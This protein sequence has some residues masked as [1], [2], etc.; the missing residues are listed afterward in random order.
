LLP[1]LLVPLPPAPAAAAPASITRD[2]IISIARS[3]V[4]CRYVWGGTCWDPANTSWKGADC[5]GYVTKCWQ[6][7]S[8]S[9]TTA[10]LPHCDTTKTFKD[11]TSHSNWYAI[12]RD[13]LVHGEALVHNNG[14]SGHI[15]LYSS[16][17][18][19]NSAYVYEAK[20]SAWGIVY[21]STYC[22]GSYVAR[23]RRDLASSTT[24][25]YPLMSITGSIAAVSGQ[26][27]DL[28]TRYGSE[29]IFGWWVGQQTSFDV[30]V[31]NSGKAAA[32][33]VRIA[34]WAEEPYLEVLRW[35]IYSDYRHPGSFTLNDTDGLQ[36]ISRSSPGKEFSLWLAGISPGE[37][38]RIK[39]LVKA[40]RFSLGAQ[41]PDIRS[42]ISNVDGYC[43]KKDFYSKLSN[44][45]GYQEHDGGDLRHASQTDILVKETCDGKDNDCDGQIDEP[46]AC[47]GP[48]P[49]TGG[50]APGPRLDGGAPAHADL[51][52][53]NTR[54]GNEGGPGALRG[55]CSLP[56]TA[57]ASPAPPALLTLLALLALRKRG[58][59]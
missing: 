29:V 6:I 13:S 30:D 44:T 2:H 53:V 37:T 52:A 7:P 12:S 15:V 45:H 32:T 50:T 49:D 31:K 4:G 35:N 38:R 59:A 20:G 16:G 34:I 28:C 48:R 57:P 27:R 54:P 46:P 25:S 55:G 3:G 22:S 19:R 10:C 14:S 11:T 26:P 5:S 24:P 56:G 39:L 40:E 33:N 8:A 58:Q 47:P 51:P 17:D 36:K 18:K 23:R 43:A 9:S 41:H 1:L 21:G 42:W